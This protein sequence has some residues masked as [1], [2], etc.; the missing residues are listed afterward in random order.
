MQSPQQANRRRRKAA[1]WQ[2]RQFSLQIHRRR[3]GVSEL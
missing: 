1:T 2:G 3:R